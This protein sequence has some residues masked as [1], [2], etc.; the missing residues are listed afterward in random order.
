M[1]SSSIGQ[2]NLPRN[3]SFGERRNSFIPE[4]RVIAEHTLEGHI[5]S[6]REGPRR[7]IQINELESIIREEKITEGETRVVSEKQLEKRR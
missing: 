5:V 2:S 3:Y 7:V 4:R 6:E 1:H